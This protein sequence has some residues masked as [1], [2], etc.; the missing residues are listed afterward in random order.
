[1][2]RN[3]DKTAFMQGLRLTL[4]FNLVIVPFAL[5]FGVLAGEAGW[6]A[7]MALAMSVVVVAGASQFAA[8]QLIQDNAPF[9]VVVLTGMAVNLRMAM[10]SAA[11][12]L[13][14]GPAPLW[15]RAL[16]AYVLTDQTYAIGVRHYELNPSMTPRE[17]VLFFGGSALAI[18]PIWN[19]FTVIGAVAGRAIPPEFGLDFAAPIT[20]IAL[21]APLLRSVPHLA[22]ALV[23]ICAALLFGFLPY[24]LWLILAAVLAMIAGVV[25]E[26]L[27]ERRA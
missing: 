20:F 3:A 2:P 4:P 19:L 1:M 15:Q 8:L 27:L 7:V 13:H 23:S 24:N 10:Y 26:S 22:A 18:V 21:F 17:K 5:L 6:D 25:V 12:V 11:L 16:A 9:I 14:L